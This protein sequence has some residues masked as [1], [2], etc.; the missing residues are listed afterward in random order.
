RDI[1]F[2]EQIQAGSRN[3]EAQLA[4]ARGSVSADSSAKS[5]VVPLDRGRTVF[6]FVDDVHLSAA[7]IYQARQMLTRYLA[8]EMG[9]NDEAAITST[10]G[11]IGF[12]QQLT[13][14]RAVL[15]AAIERLNA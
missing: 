6:F 8:R 5:P 7:S 9:Q 13:G 15:K 4:A 11:Q 12:L 14:D 10:T 3:E 2:F 1:S